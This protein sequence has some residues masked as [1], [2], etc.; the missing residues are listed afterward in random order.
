MLN[1]CDIA[2]RLLKWNGWPSSMSFRIQMSCYG[3]RN[4]H[5]STM[6]FARVTGGVAGPAVAVLGARVVTLVSSRFVAAR[7]GTLLAMPLS[8]PGTPTA[9]TELAPALLLLGDSMGCLFFL[10]LRGQRV[11]PSALRDVSATVCKPTLYPL[12][13]WSINRCGAHA[14]GPMP[15]V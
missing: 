3:R 15:A 1:C 5:P 9:V 13:G 6:L 4:L 8:L 7:T 10:D 2:Q 11:R 12:Q 14:Q